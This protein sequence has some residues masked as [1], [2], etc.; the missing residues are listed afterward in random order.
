MVPLFIYYYL[1][2]RFYY[3]YS[4]SF[5]KFLEELGRL[6]AKWYLLLISCAVINWG[7]ESLKWQFLVW[8]IEKL[9]FP[10]AVKSVL[11]GVAV[12]QLLPYKIGE[13][14]GRLAYISNENK[15]GA[16]SLSIAGS[17]SQLLV[18][19]FFGVLSPVLGIL[20]LL[21]GLYGLILCL[22]VLALMVLLFFRLP[23]LRIF[24][25]FA[26]MNKVQASL[27][28]LSQRDL[29]K[30]FLISLLRYF[31]FVLP[32]AMLAQHFDPGSDHIFLYYVSSVSAI[33][34]FLTVSPNFILT[35]LTARMSIPIVVFDFSYR[36]SSF[37]YLPGMLIYIFN[38][39]IPMCIGAVIL[40]SAK[41]RK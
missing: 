23:R 21:G 22:L 9:R 13:Y 2:N 14:L 40:M 4:F 35:D 34:F 25:R 5:K 31:S 32:Y 36:S 1:F 17:F 29:A 26:F 8:R 27:S 6:D 7:L 11:S 28:L 41:I 16:A 33:Y 12:S 39:A 37:E 10:D 18:T 24:K 30:V 38:V 3:H 15:I 20:W 19:L